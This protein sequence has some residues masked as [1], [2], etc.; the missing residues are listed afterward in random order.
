[1]K[2]DEANA[3]NI[4]LYYLWSSLLGQVVAEL[5][6]S[7]GVYRSFVYTSGALLAQ[8]SYDTAFTWL[9]T[10]HLGSG[11]RTVLAGQSVGIGGNQ[12]AA[13]RFTIITRHS[14]Y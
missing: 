4:V 14:L 11:H 8:Q 3:G 12:N 13:S 9:H 6:N 2:N 10:D 1:M 5:N 7:G